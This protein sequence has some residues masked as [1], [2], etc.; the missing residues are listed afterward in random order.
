MEGKWDVIKS[1]AEANKI[2]PTLAAS[3]M[4]Q[5]TGNGKNV[6]FNNPGGLMDPASK[7]M[8]TK[9]QFQSIDHGID[10]SVK[11]MAKI[12]GQAG[13]DLNRM[14]GIYA[15]VG[16]KNDNGDNKDWLPGVKQIAKSLGGI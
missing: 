8:K 10:A 2:S 1:S 12:Y 3:I 11:T 5:E 16:V 15:P 13:G 4:A 14:A 9:L 7:D 6:K